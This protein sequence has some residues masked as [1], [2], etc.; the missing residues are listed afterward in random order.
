MSDMPAV[1]LRDQAKIVPLLLGEDDVRV[2]LHFIQ[3]H[4]S[5]EARKNYWPQIE[6]LRQRIEAGGDTIIVQAGIEGG[7]IQGWTANCP[8][9]AIGLE[10]DGEDFLM[11]DETGEPRIIGLSTETVR[12]DPIE[13]AQVAEVSRIAVEFELDGVAVVVFQEGRSPLLATIDDEDDAEDQVRD[14]IAAGELDPARIGSSGIY[15]NHSGEVTFVRDVDML[16]IRAST[17]AAIGPR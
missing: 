8:V 4:S 13:A 10:W 15:T 11:F 12:V 2:L 1:A 14:W 16:E 17:A 5:A 9:T 7:V 3:A 6:V